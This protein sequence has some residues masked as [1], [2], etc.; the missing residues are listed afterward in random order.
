MGE[1]GSGKSSL[2]KSILNLHRERKTSISGEIIYR[3][4]NLLKLNDKELENIR[5]KKHY[6]CQISI[7]HIYVEYQ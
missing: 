5:G 6:L 3:E 1:S 2:A 4:E 7:E